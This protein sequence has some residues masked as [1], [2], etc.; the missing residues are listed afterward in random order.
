[1]D[2]E[3]Q[4]AFRIWEGNK[5][6]NCKVIN[7]LILSHP[8]FGTSLEKQW[9]MDSTSWGKVGRSPHTTVFFCGLTGS[10]HRIRKKNRDA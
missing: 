7:C 5:P 3:M 9:E 4:V 6:Q 1:M 8:V 10:V 2:L